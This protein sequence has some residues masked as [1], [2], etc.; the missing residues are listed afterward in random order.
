MWKRLET[1]N[2]KESF[3]HY[4]EK[5]QTQQG[6]TFTL[7]QNLDRLRQFGFDSACLHLHLDRAVIA[8][9]KM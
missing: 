5:I 3:D 7:E 4:V 8:A 9:Q 6:F 1:E 2:S